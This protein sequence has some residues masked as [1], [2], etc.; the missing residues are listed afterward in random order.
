MMDE[1]VLPVF[2]V[3]L[4]VYEIRSGEEWLERGVDLQSDTGFGR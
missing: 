4:F 1:A 2:L 3:F